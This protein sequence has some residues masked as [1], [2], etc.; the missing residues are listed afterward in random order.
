MLEARLK[1]LHKS[2]HPSNSVAMLDSTVLT[3]GAI[4][5]IIKIHYS[6]SIYHWLYLQ[7]WPSAMHTMEMLYIIRLSF[8]TIE[9]LSHHSCSYY[10]VQDGSTMP[11]TYTKIHLMF[12]IMKYE[13]NKVMMLW[14]WHIFKMVLCMIVRLQVN[15]LLFDWCFQ[16]TTY[17]SHLFFTVTCTVVIHEWRH[18]DVVHFNGYYT[19]YGWCLQ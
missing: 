18:L 2:P 1:K 14:Q 13:M 10:T 4:L 17:E 9:M 6:N 3:T 19:T 5:V 8:Q 11:C 7:C 15:V 16:N 12:A